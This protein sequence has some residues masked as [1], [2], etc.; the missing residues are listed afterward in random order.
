MN[1]LSL[2]DS[3]LGTDDLGLA[4]FPVLPSCTVADTP[5]VDVQEKKDAYVFDMDLPGM[6]END[7]DIDL[8]DNVLTISSKEKEAESSKDSSDEGKWL[9]RERQIGSFKR[10]FELPEDIDVDAVHASF[11]NGVLTITVPRKAVAAS[12]KKIAIAAA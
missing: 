10:Q 1:E 6:S 11:K 2:L 3:L 7:I 12:S 4:T 9:L 8:E 5:D